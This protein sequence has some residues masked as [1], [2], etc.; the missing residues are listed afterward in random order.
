[1][2]IVRDLK[3]RKLTTEEVGILEALRNKPPKETN[4]LIKHN[5]TLREYLIKWG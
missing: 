3:T 4:A 1:M 2:K 5:Q